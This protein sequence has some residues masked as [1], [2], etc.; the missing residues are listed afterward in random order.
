MLILQWSDFFHISHW[1]TWKIAFK[2]DS[3]KS[4]ML[5]KSDASYFLS[6]LQG[7]AQQI[8]RI[9]CL[10]AN[11][12]KT[13]NQQD[14]LVFFYCYDMKPLG[15]KPH[16][17]KHLPCPNNQTFCTKYHIYFLLQLIEQEVID[18]IMLNCPSV[19]YTLTCSNR[20]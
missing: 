12:P 14:E 17:G 5:Q 13:V 6:L 9:T 7:V 15:N 2:L 20:P 4:S 1:D 11:V 10:M 3:P 18:F 8:P 16:L 19:T